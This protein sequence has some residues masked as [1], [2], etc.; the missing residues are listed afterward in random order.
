M[1]AESKT[2]KSWMFTWNN[3]TEE[4]FESIKL[5][6]NVSRLVAGKEVAPTTGTP[7]I[8]GAVTFKQALRFTGVQKL[9]PKCHWTK[10]NGKDATFQYCHKEG[11][12]FEIDNREKGKRT[13]IQRAYELARNG[14]SLE[15]VREAELPFQA[16]RTYEKALTLY[17]AEDR[18][19][20]V[21][22]V[23]GASGTGKTRWCREQGADPIGYT[24]GFWMGYTG[25][26]KIL[27]DEL[28]PD[29]IH[30]GELLRAL[31]RYKYTMNVKGGSF[32]SL[33]DTVYITCP[34]RPQDFW[35][36]YVEK[37]GGACGDEKQLL[38]RISRII[39]LV[40]GTEPKIPEVEYLPA[41]DPSQP[42]ITTMMS[43]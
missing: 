43:P 4:D 33:Y 3:Y 32:P 41:L 42:S 40:G 15:E 12:S 11:Q 6:P 7:H 18:E 26:K 14:A 9:G 13:D 16:L 17:D 27:L 39:C 21:I 10:T 30:H 1:T 34:Y 35:E 8:Q 29:Q 5:W 36:Y 24:N 23:C 2:C 37:T 25:Q 38:R 19:V 31:D 28:R 20:K 22:W